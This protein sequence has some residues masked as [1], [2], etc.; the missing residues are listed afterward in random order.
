[1]QIVSLPKAGTLS[2]RVIL[3]VGAYGGLGSAAALACAQAGAQLILLGRKVP[4]LNKI[5][6]AVSAAG[7]EPVLYP[8]DLL[9]ADPVDYETLAAQI[10][11][12]FSALHGILHV[13]AAFDGLRPLE[14]YSPEE[15]TKNLHVNLTAPWMLTQACLPL[16]RKQQDAAVVFA[17][18]E[19]DRVDK[20]YWGPYGIAKHG[21]AGLISILHE[22]LESSSVRVHGLNP[23]PMRSAVRNRAYID[24]AAT[25]WPKPE[26]YAGACVQLL[27]AAGAEWRGN[28]Y[29]PRV[30]S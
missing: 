18:E 15:F 12:E 14:H 27:S 26:A 29:S 16:M 8:L 24:E 1:M 9:G 25:R 5:Y 22:E 2:G 30:D 6:D 17:Q 19:L 4:K 20:A 7:L 10:E 28:I 11:K 21:L 13:S 3:I 23:G